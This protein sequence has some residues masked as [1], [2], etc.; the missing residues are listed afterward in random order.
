MTNDT[1]EV[2]VLLTQAEAAKVLRT[3]VRNLQRIRDR[4]LIGWLPG[5]PVC[6][7]AAEIARYIEAQTKRDPTPAQRTAKQAGNAKKAGEERGRQMLL[8][9]RMRSA[10]RKP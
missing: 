9:H 2:P 8:T 7:P 1:Q 10:G 5:R 4:G 6:I 3:T